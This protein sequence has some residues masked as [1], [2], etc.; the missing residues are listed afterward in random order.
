MIYRY[1]DTA[2]SGPPRR[3]RPLR[4]TLDAEHFR[5]P[6]MRVFFW[7]PQDTLSAWGWFDLTTN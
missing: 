5:P 4:V 2:P 3:M 7:R 6:F 1:H